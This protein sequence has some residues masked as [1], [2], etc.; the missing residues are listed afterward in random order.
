[1]YKVQLLKNKITRED[2]QELKNL[3]VQTKVYW[4]WTG[5]PVFIVRNK[6]LLVLDRR[7]GAHCEEQRFTGPG[8]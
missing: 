2:Y 7:T 3:L 8:P 4:S 6:G 5:G 1:M